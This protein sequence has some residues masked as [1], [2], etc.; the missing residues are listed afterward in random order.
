MEVMMSKT[1]LQTQAGGKKVLYLGR[2]GR[3]TLSD[4]LFACK[5]LA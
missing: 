2:P 4:V 3:V 1:F 5:P